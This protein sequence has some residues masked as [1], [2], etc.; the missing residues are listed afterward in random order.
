MDNYIKQIIDEKFAS[1]KQQRYFYAKANDKTLSA[2]ERRKWGK[3]AKEF[4]DETNFKKL[5]ETAEQEIDELVDEDGNYISGN[6][7]IASKTKGVGSKFTTDDEVGIAHGMMGAFGI[8]GPINTS[9]TLK[10]WA[11]NKEFTKGQILEIAMGDALGYEET[12]GKDKNYDEAEEYFE[13]NLGLSS[14]ETEERLEKMGY[15]EE[16]PDGKIRLIENPKKYIEE[17]IDNL[18]LKKKSIGND[19]IKNKI[20]LLDDDTFNPIVKKQLKSLKQ[21]IKDNDMDINEIIE[22]LKNE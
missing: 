11:E 17:Y 18:L 12:M 21:T 6:K 15:D 19:I 3:M 5:P 9:R 14:S 16:L 2:K 4:S 20:D 22:Y 13:D 10:Y 7:P 8:G 1:K